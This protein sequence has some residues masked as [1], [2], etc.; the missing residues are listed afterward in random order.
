MIPTVN[1][2]LSLVCPPNMSFMKRSQYVLKSASKTSNRFIT[3]IISLDI[4]VVYLPLI[5][6]THQ[7]TTHQPATIRLLRNGG[8]EP[9]WCTGEHG[10]EVDEGDL[11]P[12]TESAGA[13]GGRPITMKQQLGEEGDNGALKVLLRQ[14]H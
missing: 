1:P 4:N 7:E 6:T 11:H 12:L 2:S 13:E 10:S 5:Q 3:Q 8:H 14:Q 9:V